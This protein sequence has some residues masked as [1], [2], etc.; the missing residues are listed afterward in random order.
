VYQGPPAYQ[1]PPPP[2]PVLSSKRGSSL[3]QYENNEDVLSYKT[4]TPTPPVSR[5]PT[6]LQEKLFDY[7]EDYRKVAWHEGEPRFL[8]DPQRVPRSFATPEHP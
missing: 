4:R 5:K 7:D 6:P 2:P 1:Q 3:T 8:F